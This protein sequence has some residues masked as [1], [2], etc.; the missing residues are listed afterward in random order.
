[1]ERVNAAGV[2]W[3]RFFIALVP[4]QVIQ[5]EANAVRQV[6]ADR[7]NSRKAFN[8]PP[9]VTLQPPFRWPLAEI[10]RL[11]QAVAVFAD[12]Q[13]PFSLQLQGFGAFPPRVIY[14][15]VV[16]TPALERLQADLSNYLTE[17]LSIQE[18]DPNRPFRPHMTVA[19]RD[20]TRSAFR[21]AWPEFEQRPYQAEFTVDK[22]TLLIHNQQWVT[23]SEYPCGRAKA[24]S[25]PS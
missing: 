11:L 20:L 7:F 5:S 12:E 14:I 22:L 25:G 17:Q 3:Q 16:K 19:F 23:H 2:R 13:P 6:F 10:D 24:A 15:D 21:Q 9:H 8:S 18:K 1:M 4:P